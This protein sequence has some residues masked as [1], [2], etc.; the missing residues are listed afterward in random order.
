MP[1]ILAT[2]KLAR[3]FIR[4][5]RTDQRRRTRWAAFLLESASGR[6][7]EAIAWHDHG[8]HSTVGLCIQKLLQFGRRQRSENGPG[9]ASCSNYATTRLPG[10]RT[11]HCQKS[12]ELGRARTGPLCSGA[13]LLK[14]SRFNST[15][16]CAQG[17]LRP[18]KI[19]CCLYLLHEEAGSGLR[20]QRNSS[21]CRRRKGALR[22]EESIETKVPAAAEPEC[23]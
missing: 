16:F 6:S 15:R 1:S 10:C 13:A 11:G 20:G 21:G 23:A 19:R 22:H 12:K 17:K 14:V 2:R 8:S 7:D 4:K 18:H 3:E 9:Q 5:S